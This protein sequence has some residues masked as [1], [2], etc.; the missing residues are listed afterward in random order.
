MNVRASV[1]AGE[2]SRVVCVG[3]GLIGAGWAAHFVRAGLDVVVYDPAPEREAYLRDSLDAAMPTLTRLGLAP[4]ASPDRLSFTSDLE[5]ALAGADFVQVSAVED[6][7]AK[8]ALLARIDAIVPAGVVIASSS[9]GF[10]AED[11][12]RAARH[13]ERII[14]GHPFNPPFL[15]P[16]V[17][18]AGGDRAPA[19]AALAARFYSATG[20][21]VVHLSREIDGYIGN[22]VQFA[23]FR[24]ILYMWSQGVADLATIDRAVKAGPALRW[25]VMGPSAVFFL[26][27]RD[28]SL[29]GEFVSLLLHE[30]NSG[31]TAPAGFVPDAALMERYAREVVASLG[32]EGQAQLQALRDVGVASIRTALAD[33]G[34]VVPAR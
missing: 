2:I 25:A 13:P 28:P 19:A 24:E 5:E 33:L 12:R 7:D 14:I 15:V 21:E 9:S 29:Y 17:E 30:L 3:G 22:R 23:V 18:I 4:G 8:T 20:C 16:L 11:I 26:G 27:A 34:N 31:Y 10:L 1:D 32:R 6:R